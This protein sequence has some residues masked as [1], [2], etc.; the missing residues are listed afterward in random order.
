MAEYRCEWESQN[1]CVVL[2]IPDE[3]G[4]AALTYTS[5][6]CKEA[7][8]CALDDALAQLSAIWLEMEA[9]DAQS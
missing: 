6:T 2:R 3:H 1:G 8:E 5:D 9:L 4:N 7:L